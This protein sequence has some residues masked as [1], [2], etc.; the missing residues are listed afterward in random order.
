[1]I[2][3]YIFYK[4]LILGFGH[5]VILFQIR[6]LYGF[7]IQF[8]D[9]CIVF[10]LEYTGNYCHLP[11]VNMSH[12]NHN[13][14]LRRTNLIHFYNRQF[15]KNWIW[16]SKNKSYPVNKLHVNPFILLYFF[17]VGPFKKSLFRYDV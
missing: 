10:I 11:K 1:M 14:I 4:R 9:V 13:D 17:L 15:H 2:K 16:V 5:F 7:V 3:K 6:P 12:W 8:Y